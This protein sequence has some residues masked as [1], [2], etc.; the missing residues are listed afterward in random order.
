[1][2]FFAIALFAAAASASSDFLT[3]VAEF[4]LS[5]GTIE[6]YN[7]R[8]TNFQNMDKIIQEHN[9]TK[10]T[11]KLGHNKMSTWTNQEYKKLL[12]R[13]KTGTKN[14]VEHYTLK[15][16]K[17]AASVDW[18]TA[19]AVTAVKDQGQCG[20]CWSFSTTGCLEGIWQIQGNTLTSF[21]EQ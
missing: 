1:M 2:K 9:A 6:E 20:S 13:A 8:S 4:G 3:H 5:Y 18:R 10:S 12:G 15:N 17:A 14:N 11:Y 19:G 21:S 16:V 7:F